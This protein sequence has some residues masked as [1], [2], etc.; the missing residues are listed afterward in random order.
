[1]RPDPRDSLDPSSRPATVADAVEIARR[2]LA[3]LGAIGEEIEDEWQYVQDLVDAWDGRIDAVAD[4]RGGEELSDAI[5]TAVVM[6]AGE[7]GRIADPHR[8]I[9]WLSTFPQAFLVAL[10]E[11]P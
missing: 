8:A 4:A 7:A 11:R 2:A 9:D 3:D 6:L 10:G 5:A 1:M